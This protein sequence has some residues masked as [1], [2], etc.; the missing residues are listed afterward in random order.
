MSDCLWPHELQL[1]CPSPPPGV[2]SNSCPLSQ[3]CH[4][5]ISSS[6]APFSSCPQSFPVSE[7][8]PMSR[9]LHQVAKVLELQLQRQ[10]FQWVFRAD[11]LSDWLVWAPCRSSPGAAPCSPGDSQESTPAPHFE[12]INSSV[13]SLLYG[14]ALTSVYDSWK[15]HSFD[16][17]DLVGQVMSLFFNT[18]SRFVIAFLPR[19]KRLLISWL[20]SLSMVI[21]EPKKIKSVTASTFSPSI[22][23][24]VMALDARILVF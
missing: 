16:Y 19:S 22:F 3:W 10:S 21:W 14:P 11:F 6:V 24:E 1:P 12:G 20:Q 2:C 8:F 4:P 17:R 7:S 15:N 13:L 23:Y 18:L 9:S 5:T